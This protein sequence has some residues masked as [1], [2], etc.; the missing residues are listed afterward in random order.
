MATKKQLEEIGL[1]ISCKEEL[2]LFGSIY[3]NAQRELLL[4]LVG[5]D[6]DVDIYI[7]IDNKAEELGL[8]KN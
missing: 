3:D 6:T 7:K 4:E 5:T 8:K 1:E 2:N